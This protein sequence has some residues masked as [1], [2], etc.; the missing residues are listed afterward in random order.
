MG[1]ENRKAG[2]RKARPG[3]THCKHVGN[4]LL[5][6]SFSKSTYGLGS[7]PN[8]AME[9]ALWYLLGDLGNSCDS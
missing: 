6:C 3:S 1:D 2:N 4:Y 8:K 7:V 9:T 5:S